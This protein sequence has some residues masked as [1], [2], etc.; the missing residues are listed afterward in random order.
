MVV[1]CDADFKERFVGFSSRFDDHQAAI[2]YLF[3]RSDELEQLLEERERAEEG[4]T[5]A[6]R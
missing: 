1:R 6:T 3:D 2:E 4:A 5:A